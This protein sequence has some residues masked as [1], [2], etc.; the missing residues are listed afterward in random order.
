MVSSLRVGPF[1]AATQ[2]WV[3]KVKNEM[4]RLLTMALLALPMCVRAQSQS[5]PQPPDFSDAIK[6]SRLIFDTRMRFEG[7]DQDSLA[8]DAQALTWRAHL[9]VETGKLWS[10]SLLAE[11]EL[12]WPLT[13]DYNSTINGKTQYPV[14]ADPESYDINRVQLMNTSVPKTT[15]TLGRQR[16]VLDDQRFVGNVGWR[17]NEQ[18]YDS[19]RILNKALKNT[20]LDVAYVT[21]VN[22]VFSTDSPQGTYEGNSVLTNI[23][24]QFA[25]GK[26]IGFGYW[27]DFDPIADVPAAAGDSSKT[28]GVRFAG[29]ASLKSFKLGYIASYA[30]Q[31]EYADNPLAFDLD[32]YLI[33]L[34]GSYQQINLGVGWELLEGDG[35]KGFTTPL[36][37]LHKFQ[38]WADQFLV[39]PVDGIDDRYVNAGM[40]FKSIGPFD[41]LSALAS[42]HMFTAERGAADYGTE[43]D[44][45]V[46]VGWGHFTGLVKYADYQAERL[47][48]DTT[49]FW[50]QIEYAWQ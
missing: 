11:G 32:Y 46:Q 10:T 2:A 14:V 9:G 34:S 40:T 39:T 36:A 38:G 3:P 17:Q 18:T 44:A 5:S 50:V 26:L 47:F 41:T 42:Y 45:Q 6:A 20:T 22:R 23:A 1:L 33:E 16:I 25:L 24:Y 43:L 28:F 29:D 37:T 49:K 27:L 21:Q 31:T 35:T 4:S 19:L 8:E 15:L 13:S 48:T 7:V 30:T 12:V